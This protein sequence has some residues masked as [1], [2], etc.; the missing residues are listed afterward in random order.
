VEQP[1]LDFRA[2]LPTALRRAAERYGD[3]PYIVTE[4]GALTFAA[5]ESRSRALAK[6]LIRAGVGKGTRLGVHVPVGHDWVVAWAAGARIGALVMPFSTLYAPPELGA[7][8]MRGDV[9]LLLTQPLMFGRDHEAFL[10]E[11]LPGLD[12]S[13]AGALFL[14]CAPYL[15]SIVVLGATTRLWATAARDNDYAAADVVP[16]ALLDRIEEE[17]MPADEMIV[18][19]TSGSTDEPKAVVHTH[20]AF[21]RKTSLP[22]P[23]VPPPGGCIFLGQPFFWVGGLQ[24]LGSAIQSGA[25]LVCQEKP[26]P[27]AA[28]SLIERTRATMVIGWASTVQRLRADPSFTSRDLSAIPQLT[29]P[30]GDRELRH[31]SLGMT[32]TLGPH[33][34]FARPEAPPDETMTPLPERLRGS[35]GA[36]LPYLEHKIVHPVVGHDLPE[37]EEGELC[38]RGYCLTPRMYKSERHEVFDDDGWYHT[39]DRAYFR[40]GYLFFTGRFT[41]MIKTHGA[42]VSPR[43]VEVVLEAHPDVALAF[44][45]GVPDADRGENVV[46]GIVPAPRAVVDCDE[47]RTR[48]RTQLSAY[49]VP[50]EILVLHEDEVPW[51]ASGKVDRLRLRELLTDRLML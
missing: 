11:A 17:V 20:G 41:E 8:I 24:N 48:L 21:L 25:T 10:E 34:G 49:K 2:T 3:H 43:E 7:A 28:L 15:R 35:W 30:D 32:E 19:F 18:I 39:G 14:E 44:V 37:G 16:D 9:A 1:D 38:V 40:N 42:N 27:G 26:D 50:R 5:L 45:T 33:T 23:G 31:N 22:T 36:P 47:L 6:R 51:L 13:S 29:M 46:A 4:E 12:G